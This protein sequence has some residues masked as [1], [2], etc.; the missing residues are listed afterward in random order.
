MSAASAALYTWLPVAVAV[1][2]NDDV[3]DDDHGR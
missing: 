1:H 3:N 2:V